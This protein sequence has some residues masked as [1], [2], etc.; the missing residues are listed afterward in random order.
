MANTT[1]AAELEVT[2][3]LKD[4]FREYV[5]KSRFARYTGTGANNVI[6]IKEGRQ[7][8]EVPLVTR[9]KSNGVTGS[10]TLRGNGEKIGNFGLTLTP[11]YHRH[12]VE[13][14]REELEKPNIEL[15]KAARPLLMDW[16]MELQRDDIIE[17][18]GA[19]FNGTT[20]SNYGDATA[21]A[22]DTW[23]TNNNDRI[24]YGAAKSN[25]TSGD[26]TTS[27]ATIDTTS[28]KATAALITVAKRMAQQ[29]DPHIRPIKVEEDEEWFVLFCDPFAFRDLR[30]DTT[31]SAANRDA[32]QRFDRGG[33]N[34]IFKG[35][36]LLYDAIII[37]EIPEIAVF[38]DG[39]SGTNGL[40]GGN[41][42]AD[43]LNTAGD[44]SSRV[45]A[46]FLCGQQAVS[47]GLGQRPL[48]KVDREFDYGF[49]PGVAVELK[50]DIDKSF[51]N[52]IQ[53]GVV[54]VYTSA[55]ADA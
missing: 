41:S 51:F 42:T 26:H 43:G 30:D 55:A 35:G 33:S 24:L 13:F 53:H 5:R 8:I 1:V 3:F 52:D 15:M 37:R 25:N 11:T 27:L 23:N 16:A 4:F 34:P 36:D 38:I 31:I 7:K 28:D 19:I 6:V 17:A 18:L 48:L 40:W 54:T 29:A 46:N 2:N 10:A 45:G 32:W 39:D 47:Y 14:D 22:M 44:S 50:H 9:L 21:A 20:Y 12:A 49:Q